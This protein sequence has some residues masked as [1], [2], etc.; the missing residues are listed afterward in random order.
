MTI[1]FTKLTRTVSPEPSVSKNRRRGQSQLFISKQALDYLHERETDP[2]D[3]AVPTPLSIIADPPTA[4]APLPKLLLI[5]HL[6]K[7]PIIIVIYLYL[8]KDS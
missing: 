4:F 7:A 8:C 1:V 3:V 5:R 2:D 6:C